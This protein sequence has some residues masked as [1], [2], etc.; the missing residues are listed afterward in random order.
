MLGHHLVG[1]PLTIHSGST[2]V[3][4]FIFRYIRLVQMQKF[5]LISVS[6]C[7]HISSIL[8][9]ASISLKACY[10]PLEH[11]CHLRQERFVLYLKACFAGPYIFGSRNMEYVVLDL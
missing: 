2:H 11:F 9:G 10:L 8:T 4:Q 7:R 5:A 6:A 3:Y 1:P